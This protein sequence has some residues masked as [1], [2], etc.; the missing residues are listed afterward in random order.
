MQTRRRAGLR[1][2]PGSPPEESACRGLNRQW[3]C[4]AEHS[5]SQAPSAALPARSSVPQTL[6]ASDNMSPRPRRSDESPPQCS[7]P[8]TSAHPPAEASLRSPQACIASWPLQ[9]SSIPKDILQGGPLQRGRITNNTASV[10][11]D[12]APF[13]SAS[14]LLSSLGPDCLRSRN[15]ALSI[16]GF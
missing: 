10:S 4:A 9:S 2:F 11:R 14:Q 1:S 3:P 6:P 7:V 13:T 12:Q 15:R 5:P 16:G 8:A